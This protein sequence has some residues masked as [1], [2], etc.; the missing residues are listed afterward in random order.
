MKLDRDSGVIQGSFLIDYWGVYKWLTY[1]DFDSGV[2]DFVGSTPT[3]P[4]IYGLRVS[5]DARLER[6]GA[7]AMSTI[8]R[9]EI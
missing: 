3:T 2:F 4:A 8:Y 1:P 6:V 7:S 5:L 9:R